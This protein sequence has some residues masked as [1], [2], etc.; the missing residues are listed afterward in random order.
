[1]GTVIVI[2]LAV[3]AVICVFVA[4]CCANIAGRAKGFEDGYL[5]EERTRQHDTNK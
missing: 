2:I 4:I 1:M 5:F 3:I